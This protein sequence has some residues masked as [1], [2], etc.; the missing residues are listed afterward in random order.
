MSGARVSLAA[1]LGAA[2]LSFAGCVQ[3]DDD[4]TVKADGSGSFTESM[5]V[6][7][8]AS[9]ELAEAMKAMGPARGGGGGR[10]GGDQPPEP[11]MPPPPGTPP[12]EEGASPTDAPK[13]PSDMLERLRKRWKDVTGLEVT[14]STT[15]TKDGK[16]HIRFEA[17]F[18]TLEAYASATGI[19]MGSSLVKHDDGS[20]TLKFEMRGP[21]RG[22][23]GGAGRGTPGMG[24]APP[25]G[26]EDGSPGM[27]GGEVPP[28][29]PGGP[30][31]TGGMGGMGGMMQPLLEK[32]LT[33]LQY[34]RK[35]KLP[36]TIV[37][38]NGTKSEDGTTVT[39]KLTYDDLK[40]G[41]LE[42]QSVTF[43]GEG[44]DLKPFTVKRSARRSLLG[45]AGPGGRG[46]RGAPGAPG[47]GEGK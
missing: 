41:A 32:Y 25:G 10:N 45:P 37:E 5:V 31:G 29:A 21:G 44:L 18:T 36:G 7:L 16:A 42:P 23:R 6:D 3:T 1:L 27:E 40:G 22:G 9:A 30:G 24:D 12:P 34:V 28:G 46:G 35:L 14:K 11:P 17:T 4:V 26:M 2:A 43:K 33:G 13:P 8:G 47:G 19:E 39:W 20:Y 15:E 38:T